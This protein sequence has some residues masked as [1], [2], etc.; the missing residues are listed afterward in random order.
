MELDIRLLRTFRAVADTRSF[1]AAAKK[2]K[3]TQSS[4][5]QQI[6]ALER[7]LGVQ[8]L[9]RSNKFVGLTTAGEI[10]LQCARQMIDNLDRVRAMLAD[11][12]KTASGHLSIGA[13]ALFCHSLF[14]V[15][16]GA[17]HSRF[18][19]IALSVLTADPDSMAARLAHRELD[20]ALLPFPAKQHS[21]GMVPLGRDELVAIVAP[22]HALARQDRLDANQLRGQPLIVPNPGNKLWAAWDTFLLEAGV[23]PEIVVETDDLDLAK[24]LAIEGHGLTIAPRWSV[25]A[26][27]ARGELRTIALGAVG[28][29]VRRFGLLRFLPHAG[30]GGADHLLAEVD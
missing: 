5:S 18:P 9:R 25:L 28:G 26:E 3:L 23:F 10:F 12:S 4:V 7:E 16:L 14:P 30:I 17:F 6:I 24:R 15:V 2:L 8:L 29:G 13:P 20:L 1:T 11:Q 27:V 22:S 19:G 21:L